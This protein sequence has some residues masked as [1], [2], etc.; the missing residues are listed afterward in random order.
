MPNSSKLVWERGAVN[1]LDR[2][3]KFIEPHN[4]KAALNAARKIINSANLLLQNPYL[5]HPIEGILEFNEL[6]VPFGKRGY[7]IRYR[8]DNDKILILRIWH[9][10]EN[11]YI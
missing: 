7:I 1:D 5:G 11:K 9:G 8:I 6:F 4:S 3:R 10:R 2:L